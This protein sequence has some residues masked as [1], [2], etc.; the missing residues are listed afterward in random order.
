MADRI[1]MQNKTPQ[2]L[3]SH[4]TLLSNNPPPKTALTHLTF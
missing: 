2:T 3:S 1:A 4:G